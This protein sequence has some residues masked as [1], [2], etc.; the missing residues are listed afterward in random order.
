[1]ILFSKN[2]KSSNV[3][4]K[5]FPPVPGIPLHALGWALF[6]PCLL[7]LLVPG[8]GAALPGVHPPRH[9]DEVKIEVLPH[10]CGHMPIRLHV[11]SLEGRH[12]QPKFWRLV[13][14]QSDRRTKDSKSPNS[15]RWPTKKSAIYSTHRLL[16]TRET[17]GSDIVKNPNFCPTWTAKSMA[18]WDVD[19]TIP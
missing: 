12:V 9:H 11:H 19:L 10:C 7:K 14:C 13:A 17:T 15:R 2:K 1:M 8:G 4:P 18:I 16:Y 3:S 5:M 6:H